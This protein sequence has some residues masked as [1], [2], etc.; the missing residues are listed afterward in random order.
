[1]VGMER[2]MT[3]F[4]QDEVGD[5]VAELSC[6]HD[7]HVRHHLPFQS[8]PWVLE[9]A[10]RAER[11][12]AALDCPLCDRAELPDATRFVRATAAWD[13]QT[14]PSGLRQAHRVGAS[15][16]GRIVVERGRLRFSAATTPPLD[17][18]LEPGAAQAI[19]PEVD[20]EVEPCGPVRFRIDFYAVDRTAG[21]P[22]SEDT[23]DDPP[24]AWPGDGG[25]V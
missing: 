15:T 24:S 20:H 13:E 1:M 16:W 5:W 4:H 14:M 9:A 18:V 7:Q 21:P 3:G 2:A 25:E 6:G 22:R 19:P 17:V 12:G 8:R 11:I 23:E 10:G